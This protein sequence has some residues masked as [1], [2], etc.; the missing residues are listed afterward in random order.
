MLKV[1]PA[2]RR[3]QPFD[4]TSISL[5][6]MELVSNPAVEVLPERIAEISQD[7]NTALLVCEI[8]G[9]ICGTA[10]ISLCADVMF[11]SQPFAVVENVVVSSLARSQGIGTV[12]FRHIEAFCLANDCSKIMLLSSTNRE[13]AHRFFERMGFAGS[14]KHGFIKYR[15]NFVTTA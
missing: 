9:T 6:Y 3:A 11:R 2:V 1:E 14:S 10:L 5:L 15:S 4:A 7:G 13:H 12:L 8:H